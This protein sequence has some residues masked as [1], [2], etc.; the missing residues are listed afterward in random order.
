[1]LAN[2]LIEPLTTAV[3]RL[4][5]LGIH[6]KLELFRLRKV[7]SS[8]VGTSRAEVYFVS[9]ERGENEFVHAKSGCSIHAG[10][11]TKE[12]RDAVVTHNDWD[13][14]VRVALCRYRH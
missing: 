6:D 12:S 5:H 8:R 14:V 11:F 4:L 1:M 7:R 9:S 13:A 10:M 2:K 3:Y